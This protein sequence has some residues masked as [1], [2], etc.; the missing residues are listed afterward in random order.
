[1]KNKFDYLINNEFDVLTLSN[2]LVNL[3][4]EEIFCFGN[5]EEILTSGVMVVATDECGENH[6]KISFN[7]KYENGIDED[8]FSTIIF[9][10]GI[11]IF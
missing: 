11:E 1:M 5:L 10:T 9:I 8:L 7:I 3:G 6:I 4:C 2:E